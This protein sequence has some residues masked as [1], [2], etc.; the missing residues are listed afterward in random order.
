MFYRVRDLVLHV[1]KY[2]GC[3]T[4]YRNRHFFNN[5]TTNEKLSIG[6]FQQDGASSHTSHANMAEIQSFF[7]DHLIIIKLLK[8]CPVYYELRINV[9]SN[10]T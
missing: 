4:R 3:P 1:I 9:F 5:V 6:Y 7:G 8:K 10:I 2:I